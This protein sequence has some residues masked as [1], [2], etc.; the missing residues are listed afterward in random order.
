MSV[1]TYNTVESGYEPSGGLVFEGDW[2]R[3]MNMVFVGI[4]TVPEDFVGSDEIAP[5]TWPADTTSVEIES[6]YGDNL[7][8]KVT[9]DK[10][11]DFKA[12]TSIF[13]YYEKNAVDHFFGN[14][15]ERKNILTDT[16]KVFFGVSYD[17]YDNLRLGIDRDSLNTIVYGSTNFG[18]SNLFRVQPPPNYDL[19]C[20]VK[21]ISES[22]GGCTYSIKGFEM[23]WLKGASS[24]IQMIDGYDEGGSPISTV[25]S[26][27]TSKHY[28]G[29]NGVEHTAIND[30]GRY[31]YGR[32]KGHIGEEFQRKLYLWKHGLAGVMDFKSEFTFRIAPL[33]SSIDRYEDCKI[34]IYVRI[35]VSN[36][37][38]NIRYKISQVDPSVDV[39]DLLTFEDNGTCDL[40]INSDEDFDPEEV[41]NAFTSSAS[42]D[43]IFVRQSIMGLLN[44]ESGIE[45][46]NNPL[47]IVITD[48]TS[49][50]KRVYNNYYLGDFK[51]FGANMSL[52]FTPFVEELSFTSNG[53]LHGDYDYTEMQKR[54]ILSFSP[55]NESI[56]VTGGQ[57][58]VGSLNFTP[59][60]R[61]FVY[62]KMELSRTALY[63][64]VNESVNESWIRENSGADAQ[65]WVEWISNGCNDNWAVTG[66]I[67]NNGVTY[68]IADFLFGAQPELTGYFFSDHANK[69][70]HSWTVDA[71]SNGTYIGYADTLEFNDI[72]TKCELIAATVNPSDEVSSDDRY[73]I[74][75]NGAYDGDLRIY[76][77]MVSNG[78]VYVR[79]GE[80]IAYPKF[81]VNVGCW[82]PSIGLSWEWVN[83]NS[84][85]YYLSGINLYNNYRTEDIFHIQDGPDNNITDMAMRYKCPENKFPESLRSVTLR[86]PLKNKLINDGVEHRLS[87]FTNILSHEDAEESDDW[88]PVSE[89]I[90]IPFKIYGKKMS[91]V[92]G[93]KY[94][95]ECPELNDDGEPELNDDEEVVTYSTPID[96]DL[97]F[98]LKHVS[99]SGVTTSLDFVAIYSSD[100]G[101]IYRE[102]RNHS[103]TIPCREE[104]YIIPTSLNDDADGY[105][106]LTT[107][108]DKTSVFGSTAGDIPDWTIVEPPVAIN[109]A[110]SITNVE[111]LPV[112]TPAEVNKSE[113]AR[114]YFEVKVWAGSTI[115]NNWWN[116]GYISLVLG[117]STNFDYS[118]YTPYS[119]V[120]NLVLGGF[121]YELTHSNFLVIVGSST[122]GSGTFRF[123]VNDDVQTGGTR[124]VKRIERIG[125]DSDEGDITGFIKP[126]IPSSATKTPYIYVSNSSM[127]QYPVY[128][129]NGLGGFEWRITLDLNNNKKGDLF[130]LDGY[131]ESNNFTIGIA[132]GNNNSDVFLVTGVDILSSGVRI[133]EYDSEYGSIIPLANIASMENGSTYL[134]VCTRNG[135]EYVYS[136]VCNISS[137]TSN[138]F[139]FGDVFAAPELSFT[140]DANGKF[141]SNGFNYNARD[142]VPDFAEWF[143]SVIDGVSACSS[144]YVEGGDRPSYYFGKKPDLT[145]SISGCRIVDTVSVVVNVGGVDKSVYSAILDA[146]NV[147]AVYSPTV[148]MLK[149]DNYRVVFTRE[150]ISIATGQSVINGIID[151]VSEGVELSGGNYRFD[152]VTNINRITKCQIFDMPVTP[153]SDDIS[154]Y[155]DISYKV[156]G[157]AF[158]NK[159]EDPKN[160]VFIGTTKDVFSVS[161]VIDERAGYDLN[162]FDISDAT[163]EW[164]IAANS[165]SDV[166][167]AGRDTSYDQIVNTV[168]NL[169]GSG[170]KF[171]YIGK[172]ARLT[173]KESEKETLSIGEIHRSDLS[174][175]NDE[176]VSIKAIIYPV[177]DFTA[178][179]VTKGKSF[180]KMIGSVSVDTPIEY[181]D[182]VMYLVPPVLKAHIPTR[183]HYSGEKTGVFVNDTVPLS[184][185]DS[186]MVQIYGADFGTECICTEPNKICF[187]HAKLMPNDMKQLDN[188]S[189]T[190]DSVQRKFSVDFFGIHNCKV[191]RRL[192]ISADDGFMVFNKEFD[193]PTRIRELSYSVPVLP[194]SK[195]DLHIPP[196]E[197]LTADNFNRM[198]DRLQHDFEYLIK[199]AYYYDPA[200]LGVE[201]VIEKYKLGQSGE[202]TYGNGYVV[203]SSD[204]SYSI[205]PTVLY[206]ENMAGL[207]MPKTPKVITDSNKGYIYARRKDG[208]ILKIRNGEN[209]TSEA[210][211]LQII[212]VTENDS[213]LSASADEIQS[214]GINQRGDIFVLVAKLHRIFVFTYDN[215]KYKVNAVLGGIGGR[216]AKLKFYKPIDLR[217]DNIDRMWV[218][219]WGNKCVKCY[220]FAGSYL[221]TID[222]PEEL[223]NNEDFGDP[224]KCVPYHVHE[225]E[226]DDPVD[227]LYI[228][229]KKHIAVIENGKLKDVWTL[230][231]H[232][233]E[234]GVD[235]ADIDDDGK[236]L[237]VS[238]KKGIQ[239]YFYDGTL[240]ADMSLPDPIDSHSDYTGNIYG[241]T[242]FGSNL[243][244]II[245]KEL[246]K[247]SGGSE[248]GVS[249][250]IQNNFDISSGHTILNTDY[251]KKL[252]KLDDLYV[253]RDESIQDVIINTSL[254][255][256]SD[257]IRILAHSLN[258][259]ILIKR[260]DNGRLYFDRIDLS[261]S[262]IRQLDIDIKNEVFVG[263]NELVTADV[264]NRCCDK[265]YNY[266]NRTLRFISDFTE[267]Y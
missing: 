91:W 164:Y 52:N 183:V 170:R 23:N 124:F 244:V 27:L 174:A 153:P 4:P 114:Y 82:K 154:H 32:G 156:N 165:Y 147:F 258:G 115:M 145:P 148:T 131:K 90:N 133:F 30:N 31:M 263:V 175:K 139:A 239:K 161:W 96:E 70:I 142:Y 68:N 105:L 225:T 116:Y 190:T 28:L 94:L 56:P 71:S 49:V 168:K 222:I 75:S 189:F 249:C 79:S 136:F 60:S 213:R 47:D 236:Y 33:N 212:N 104:V 50:I 157:S 126:T 135:R 65:T 36:G 211:E 262:D 197:W 130:L 230:K 10:P 98:S 201:G 233:D 219:D 267:F 187:D 245:E 167:G 169:W 86:N 54:T 256:F 84:D 74:L 15:T 128:K 34:E 88:T 7:V 166:V 254:Q 234:N 81:G 83:A 199:T 160:I 35:D 184:G 252:W 101:L 152:G 100:I 103:L 143:L 55:T 158:P 243:S 51:V 39:G 214:Y 57:C 134:M 203:H 226:H 58:M 141:L 191:M 61:G 261:E 64:I 5:T 202:I 42:I 72:G 248:H 127:R 11:S 172:E 108:V 237:Y 19:N 140:V 85:K 210:E 106:V 241:C 266:M 257:N 207:S 265:L 118:V 144:V 125:H 48:G 185:F 43:R 67:V 218:F 73:S 13:S 193:N 224:L 150:I 77:N 117:G 246:P 216:D 129:M 24:I 1:Y 204:P 229:F 227:M 16:R 63:Y 97:I 46:D 146:Q 182:F 179:G 113:N 149:D 123:V 25:N 132:R 208:C 87:D 250:I 89:N 209:T 122:E 6:N 99:N 14:T 215:G 111:I 173:I 221:S 159:S 3:W 259:K 260:M 255:R 109:D 45:G 232:F 253:D 151:A 9:T 26:V 163:C 80:N 235:D 178:S 121:K 155:M 21:G 17:G 176:G 228:L 242:R 206:W 200:P 44:G 137:I 162:P 138:L 102:S 195:L 12:D 69:Q 223:I 38:L 8:G 192:H 196:N 180:S 59:T 2:L 247:T 171:V 264:L 119:E 188:F 76:P 53:R 177:L 112:T 93:R 198:I 78:D 66:K 220:T 40:I 240:V 92:L 41:L 95:W 107:S 181:Q 20:A 37:L 18:Y 62:K 120:P 110:D 231:L 217:F 238:C 251:E 205:K 186:Y 22:A 194:L 29:A